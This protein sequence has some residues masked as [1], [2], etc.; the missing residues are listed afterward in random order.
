M[1]DDEPLTIDETLGYVGIGT[2][3]GYSDPGK[4]QLL[5]LVDGKAP[6]I[7]G[8]AWQQSLPVNQN[9]EAVTVITDIQ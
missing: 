2:P 8:Q 4:R 5:K 9:P 6:H 3:S 7:E 1:G